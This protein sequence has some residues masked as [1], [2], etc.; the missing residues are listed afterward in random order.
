MAKEKIVIAKGDCHGD[1]SDI[2]YLMQSLSDRGIDL[3][4]VV[5]IIAGDF[6]IPWTGRPDSNRENLENLNYFGCDIVALLGNHEWWNL[7]YSMPQGIFCGA[8]VHQCFYDNVWYENIHY[9]TD[10]TVMTIDRKKYLL[11]PG[12]DSHDIRDGIL[13]GLRPIGETEEYNDWFDEFGPE[14]EDF[15]HSK[16]DELG[17]Y[18]QFRVEGL[19]WF[20]E[21]KIQIDKVCDILLDQN[22]FHAVVS[23]DAPA[24]FAY[25]FQHRCRSSIFDIYPPTD[26]EQRLDDIYKSIRF[27]RWIHGHFHEDMTS[28]EDSRVTISYFVPHVLSDNFQLRK[29]N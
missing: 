22:S 4:D 10:P 3:K 1:C 24:K 16:Y 29:N 12:A 14:I 25:E 15:A 7:I 18:P 8:N 19:S 2:L 9:V 6:G 28:R 21:E 26:D 20:R 17:Y 5:I 23:H 11:I 27:N 13:T